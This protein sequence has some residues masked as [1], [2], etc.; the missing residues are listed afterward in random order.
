MLC[1]QMSSSLRE[2][3]KRSSRYFTSPQSTLGRSA[4]FTSPGTNDVSPQLGPSKNE[5]C[6]SLDHYDTE[7][8]YP[9]DLVVQDQGDVSQLN[10]RK[11]P[12]SSEN[13]DI[14]NLTK[15]TQETL[16]LA[17]SPAVSTRTQK[18][19]KSREPVS[20][21]DMLGSPLSSIQQLK[22]AKLEVQERTA[23]KDETLRKLN[24]VKMYR[25]KVRL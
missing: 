18:L 16:S 25:A 12:R 19:C 9:N 11:R 24:L 17:V 13:D 23:R 22:Q 15:Q 2:R 4:T 6:S 8:S 3:L 1:L 5:N 21:S 14:Q 20:T 7:E 10:A